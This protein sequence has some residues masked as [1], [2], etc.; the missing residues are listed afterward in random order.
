MNLQTFNDI[1]LKLSIPILILIT[2]IILGTIASSLIKKILTEIE[3]EKIT[4]EKTSL[5]I[6]INFIS[7]LVKY[8]IY[9]IGLLLAVYFTGFLKIFLIIILVLVSSITLIS[10]SA[11]LI[12]KITNLNFKIKDKVKLKDKIRI[13]NITGRV[14]KRN[15]FETTIKNSKNEKVTI[16]N[17]LLKN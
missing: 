5:N 6:P 7:P 4:K 17:K 10:L 16:P 1:L 9:L 13:K 3:L 14:I 12:M 2:S 11:Y 15:I 8:T